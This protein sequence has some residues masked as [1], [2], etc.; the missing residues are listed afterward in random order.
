MI[1]SRYVMAVSLLLTS[2]SWGAP[3]A[4]AAA[5]E[6][7]VSV[8]PVVAPNA[9]AKQAPER[10]LKDG[11]REVILS[12]NNVVAVDDYV[13]DESVTK[14]SA[15]VH[16]L[17]SSLPSGDPIYLLINSGGGSIES[18]I[19]LIQLLKSLNRPVNTITT[20]GASMA[21]HAVQGVPNS[22]LVTNLGV[23][24]SHKARGGFIGEFPGQLDSRYQFWL[25]LVAK[26]DADVI[27][28]TGGLLN[29]KSYAQLIE[30]EYWCSGS[31]CVKQGF[32]DE[33]VAPSCDA[34]LAGTEWIPVAKFLYGGLPVEVRSQHSKCPLITGELDIQ[35]YIAGEPLFP[36][37]PTNEEVSAAKSKKLATS[38]S[39]YRNYSDDDMEMSTKLTKDERS[40]L[41]QLLKDIHA[42]YTNRVVVQDWTTQVSPV[43]LLINKVAD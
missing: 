33:V 32:A 13:Y 41:M 19:Q 20:F 15:R 16:A 30:N 6:A 1:F 17:D 14:W 34:S 35:I 8:G 12:A 23:L 18:G 42:L 24:M 11:T 25:R 26:L 2:L 40:R 29:N 4:P 37:I 28:R 38:N 21:F 31:D 43:R 5:P 27:A 39:Y 7:K 9:A 22:R 10:H 36:R 3:A